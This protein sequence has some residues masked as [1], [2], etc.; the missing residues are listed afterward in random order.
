MDYKTPYPYFHTF[1]GEVSLT[2]ISIVLKEFWSNFRSNQLS[3]KKVQS[4]A[5]SSCKAITRLTWPRAASTS[6][7][8]AI[9]PW[10]WSNLKTAILLVVVWI[11]ESV[12]S[13]VQLRLKYFTH[14]PSRAVRLASE[15][16]RRMWL[17]KHWPVLYYTLL[18]Y[19]A[20]SCYQ[21]YIACTVLQAFKTRSNLYFIRIINLT[22]NLTLTVPE[23]VT[24]VVPQF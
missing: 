2:H 17:V 13:R 18:H 23:V 15:I 5:R 6:E 12:S 20:L 1:A 22:T 11:P 24:V 16:R 21:L 9:I 14:I 4:G 3:A 10:F 8:K 19:A 7:Q